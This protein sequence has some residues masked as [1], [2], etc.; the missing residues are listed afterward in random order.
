MDSLCY[1]GA[2]D[3]DDDEEES[4]SEEEVEP[5]PKAQRTAGA[6]SS[7]SAAIDYDA[8]RRAGFSDTASDLTQTATFQ[9]LEAESAA[10]LEAEETRRKEEERERAEYAAAQEKASAELLNRKKIDES[11]GYEKRYDRTREDFR[12]KEK[13]KRAMGQQN[14]DGN[15]VEEEKRRLRHG[16][17]NFDS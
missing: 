13:R 12:T 1:I 4:E 16:G 14:R 15:Y 9:R 11:L 17:A 3:D 5:E 7:S 6:G 10:K 2:A 8:L